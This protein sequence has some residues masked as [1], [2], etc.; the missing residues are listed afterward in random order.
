MVI[1][2]VYDHHNRNDELW[3]VFYVFPLNKI[4]HLWDMLLLGGSSFPLCIGVAILTQLKAL[5]LKADFNE[6]ILLF[7]ELPEIDIE[8]CVR[9]SIDIFASTPRSC[10]YREHASDL[11]NYQI[12]NDLDMNPF[13]LADL[14]FE[15]CPRISANDVVELNDLKAPTASLKT[16]KLLL[17]DI[18]TPDE[19]MKAAL[20]ASVNIPYENAFDDQNRITDNRL[21]HLLD[22]HRSLVKVVIGNK[23]YKQIVDFTNNL[24]INN[25]TRVCLL[26]KGI[27]VFKTTGMLYVPTPSD[28]P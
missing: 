3:V 14:K 17:I 2:T 25:A 20:P 28:L 27:D 18:R 5:L 12:N 7:S 15:R 23:N 9:D 6:C 13:P 26:H 21:Q 24:I 16:S 19:Y 10:T 11:T 22:Q 8:R 1:I 4:F